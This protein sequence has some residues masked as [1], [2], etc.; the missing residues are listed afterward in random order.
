[1]EAIEISGFKKS[2]KTGFFKHRTKTG[3]KSLT[4]TVHAGEIFGYLGP[5]GA[6][7]TTTLK[8][9]M[10]LVSPS[11]GGARIL[12]KDWRDASV[13]A[14]IGF[15]PEQP[16]RVPPEM[17]AWVVEDL[18]QV[19]VDKLEAQRVDVGQRRQ[20]QCQRHQHARGVRTVVRADNSWRLRY[21]LLSS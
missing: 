7:K 2:Y 13:R 17:D 18:R 9:L 4:L 20:R 3:L 5:N 10:G 19:I 11:A 15:L 1:M 6:G 21:R 16:G 8:L 12:G 14:R